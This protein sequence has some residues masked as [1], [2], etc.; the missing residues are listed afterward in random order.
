ME[1][2]DLTI[3]LNVPPQLWQVNRNGPSRRA[4]NTP[5]E[6][7]GGRAPTDPFHDHDPCTS[8]RSSGVQPSIAMPA[9]QLCCAC[10]LVVQ[11]HVA[12]AKLASMHHPPLAS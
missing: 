2:Y 8:S 5:G 3:R 6:Q 10:L 11:R 12:G 1:E 7:W 9:C 4:A